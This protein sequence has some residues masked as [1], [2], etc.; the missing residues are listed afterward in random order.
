M[1][2]VFHLN[3]IGFSKLNIVF[4]VTSFTLVFRLFFN[5]L[6]INFLKMSIWIPVVRQGV[7]CF[8]SGDLGCSW[9]FTVISFN[10]Q[11]GAPLLVPFLVFTPR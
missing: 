4:S 6:Q 11:R 3:F 9:T 8:Y 1:W 10:D 7:D 5:L 2:G